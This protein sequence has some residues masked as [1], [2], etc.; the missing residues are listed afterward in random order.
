VG[1]VHSFQTSLK[2]GLD[3]FIF[4]G[5]AELQAFFS[6]YYGGSADDAIRFVKMCPSLIHKVIFGG[7][8][9]SSDLPLNGSLFS[10]AG[11]TDGF[12]VATYAIFLDTVPF[13]AT[14]LG[15]SNDDTVFDG[16]WAGDN[17]SYCF[18]W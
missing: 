3:G 1:S 4:E 5:G 8:T 6:S 10:Y 13:K 7:E 2:G 17:C 15:G 9:E 11:N 18:M 12:I 14:Y 16:A